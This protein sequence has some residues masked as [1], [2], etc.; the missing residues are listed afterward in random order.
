MPL[1]S[2]L[3]PSLLV[4]PLLALGV[5]AHGQE[6]ALGTFA[7]DPTLP[8]EI[9]SETLSVDQATGA[10]RFEGGV[11][12]GQG[13]LRLGAG[14]VEVRT[15]A[16][17]GDIVRLLASGGVTM[18]TPTEA[19]E[20][21]AA[22]YDLAGQ[23]LTLTGDVLLTQGGSAIAADRMVLDLAAGTARMEGGVRTVLQGTGLDGAGPEGAGPEAAP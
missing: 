12:I 10:A 1:R 20:A 11:V 6:V 22:D 21:E 15:D 16:G 5:P 13:D 2:R 9:E 3:G 19:A 7:A 17:T 18:A 8:V 4:L 23:T 14:A